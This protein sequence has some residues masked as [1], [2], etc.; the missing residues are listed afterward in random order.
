MPACV[1]DDAVF[2]SLHLARAQGVAQAGHEALV[3]IPLPVQVGCHLQAM[4]VDG[5]VAAQR[6]D[7]IDRITG[8]LDFFDKVHGFPQPQPGR[9]FEGRILGCI[10]QHH[11]HFLAHD[12]APVGNLNGPLLPGPRENLISIAVSCKSAMVRSLCCTNFN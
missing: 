8:F 3:V 6:A 11:Q 1:E 12:H 10:G 5:Y 9:P 2:F 7:I 4:W